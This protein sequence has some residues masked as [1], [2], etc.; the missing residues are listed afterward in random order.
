[1]RK[2]AVFA[3]L[4]ILA[5][6]PLFSPS[7]NGKLTSPAPLVGVAFAGHT[8]AGGWCECGAPGCIC[9]PG[10]LGGSSRPLPNQTE[11]PSRQNASANRQHSRSGSDFG[12]GALMLALAFFVW[13]RLRA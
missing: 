13:T 9:E 10:E 4:C 7:Q 5:V 6:P 1:M 11:N 12:T 8:T 2:R 3:T